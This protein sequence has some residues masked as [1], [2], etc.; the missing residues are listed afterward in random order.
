MHTYYVIHTS[1]YPVENERRQFESSAGKLHLTSAKFW[2]MILIF[3]IE[4]TLPAMIEL[5]LGERS[6]PDTNPCYWSSLLGPACLHSNTTH[7]ALTDLQRVFP[8]AALDL[9]RGARTALPDA[10]N[11][12]KKL[13]RS[14]LVFFC[15]LYSF[16]LSGLFSLFPFCYRFI[17]IISFSSLFHLFCP[18]YGLER[19]EIA[20]AWQ[21]RLIGSV[22]PA[23]RG[24]SHLQWIKGELGRSRS[25]PGRNKCLL[26]S[27]SRNLTL[28]HMVFGISYAWH[29]L[30]AF[31]CQ[32]THPR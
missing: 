24:S 29:C 32:S 4:N 26:P 10:E 8:S 30:T 2:P 11:C 22:K 17:R 31:K 16:E 1:K 12:T 25:Y 3:S 18:L 7:R 21:C 13:L 23:K 27:L 5:A 28:L 14:H 15:L 9:M 19:R 20:K 6:L